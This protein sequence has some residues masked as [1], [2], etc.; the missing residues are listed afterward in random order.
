[1]VCRRV[2]PLVVAAVLTVAWAAGGQA[3]TNVVGRSL[4][5]D[6]APAD[7]Q[8]LRFF[9][10]PAETLDV[11]ATL[12]KRPYNTDSN[13]M[14]DFFGNPL[15]RSDHNFEFHPAGATSWEASKDGTTWTFHLDKRYIWS[16]GAPVTA[17]DYVA[18]F[19]YQADPKHAWDFAWYYGF[20][21]NWDEAV[22]GTVS[23]DQIGV[24]RG[25]DPYTLVIT[26]KEPTPFL[27]Q[28]VIY[29]PALNRQ[30]LEKYGPTYNNDPKTSISSGPYV[31]QEWTKDQRI[32]L[33]ANPKYGGLKPYITRVEIKFADLNTEFDA[34]RNNEVD[35]AANF[36]PAQLQAVD[37]DPALRAQYH[38]GLDDFRINYLGFDTNNPPFNN[39]KVRQAFSHAIDREALVKYVIKEQG[40]PAYGMMETGFPGANET[41]L[42]PIQEFDPALAKK[43]LAEAG[44][45][46]GQ[47]F[48]KLELW[49]RNE[50]ALGQAVGNAIGAMLKQNL[51]VQVDISN[52]ERKLFMDTLN[53][54]KLQF[55][56]VSYGMDY[57]DPSNM[58]GIWLTGG[59]HT[60]SNPEFDRLM[61]TAISMMGDEA[62]RYRMF[63]QAEK[64][65][66]S[67]VG[68]IPI[69]HPTPGF[70]WKPYVKGEALAPNKDG[71]AIWPWQGWSGGSNMFESVYISRDVLN[72]RP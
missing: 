16:D 47:G 30:Y 51:G 44:Y 55:Y 68:L 37:R 1:M 50:A 43:L 46:G 18:T 6:A 65:L 62:V 66:V 31:L 60:W 29:S 12:Y 49:L 38:R 13:P 36:S 42:K 24:Q 67:D 27:Y 8:T 70:L 11:W 5:D 63:Q 19:R 4:P 7:Q 2:L 17:D 21:K 54:H 25:P 15:I 9:S 72:Y 64:I 26:A 52:K 57:L 71:M 39:L 56:L 23:L 40:V 69:F 61:K 33:V 48:P 59:R 58:L 53:S 10:Q 41:A 28:A 35:V 20:I 45:P 34:Y 14:G 22:K 3:A 32:V